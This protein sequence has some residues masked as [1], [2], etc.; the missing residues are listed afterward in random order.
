VIE[1]FDQSGRLVERLPLS[2]RDENRLKLTGIIRIVSRHRQD[3]FTHPSLGDA[4]EIVAFSLFWD[5]EKAVT[6]NPDA[7]RRHIELKRRPRAMA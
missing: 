7:V 4:P 1:V 3:E 2:E 6:S 5:G